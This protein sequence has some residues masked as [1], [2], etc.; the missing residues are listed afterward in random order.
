MPHGHPK[1]SAWVCDVLHK[2][3]RPLLNPKGNRLVAEHTMDPCSDH[4]HLPPSGF[5]GPR[6]NLQE[7]ILYLL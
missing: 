4:S 7:G 5:Q 1:A 2:G 3:D 6:Y